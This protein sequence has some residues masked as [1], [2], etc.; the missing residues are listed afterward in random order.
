MDAPYNPACARS[1]QELAQAVLATVLQ[2]G[3]AEEAVVPA[4]VP[5][6]V[7][8]FPVA[9]T[10]MRVQVITGITGYDAD[11]EM[12][13]TMRFPLFTRALYRAESGIDRQ[14]VRPSIVPRA[15]HTPAICA[16]LL[17]QMRAAYRMA[18]DAPTCDRCGAPRIWSAKQNL[19]CG[20][21]C[22]LRSSCSATAGTCVGGEPGT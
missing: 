2:A 12:V 17:Q 8:Y 9:R 4:D 16:E 14:V 5:Q 10:R 18:R 19:V 1:R 7:F 20:E 11:A 22:F 3:F 6:R 13:F 21:L 15:G